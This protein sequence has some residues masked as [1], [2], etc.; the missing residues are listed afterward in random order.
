MQIL[1]YILL[2]LILLNIPTF[3]IT[4]FSPAIGG[5][6]SLLLI[7]CVIIYYVIEKKLNPV[8]PLLLLGLS[9]YIIS[10]LNFTGDIL[11][12]FKDM[13]RYF[14]IILG[15]RKL[16]SITT[17]N[18]FGILLLIGAV[19]I[20]VHA[21]LF[22]TVYGRYSGFYINPNM[23]GFICIIGF[24]F[25]FSISKPSLKLTSQFIFTLAGILTLSRT[26]ILLLILVNIIA[27][28]VNRK[29]IIT[30]FAG[31]VALTFIIAFS[32]IK[33]NAD[34]FNAL[35]S[36]FSDDI[37]TTT[38]TEAS[39]EETWVKYIDGIFTYPVFG[40][41]YKKL[42]GKPKGS[43]RGSDRGVHNSFLMILGE[44]G[45]IPFFIAVFFYISM[46]FKSIN[47]IKTEPILF[48]L[49][50][51]LISYLMVSHNYFDNFIILFIS[52]WL[53]EKLNSADNKT[54]IP[55]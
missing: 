41:G 32:T 28:C 44:A 43:Y 29:N 6:S 33:L 23:A 34:R 10:G 55:T 21:L 12:F 48:I 13:I 2:I 46:F 26:F 52:V 37:D 19:S 4:A 50:I 35:K 9:Y 31:A 14:V 11:E 45:I 16:A 18:D 3:S 51:L 24:A 15:T 20:I 25:T 49:S 22:S 8:T 27:I 39:R 17:K 42:H 36:I 5:I 1:K 38:I 54:I 30:L 40:Q 47:V 53:Y 7:L